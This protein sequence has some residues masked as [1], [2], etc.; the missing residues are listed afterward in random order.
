MEAEKIEAA[1]Q[2]CYL[3]S[4]DDESVAVKCFNAFKKNLKENPSE[5]YFALRDALEPVI[6]LVDWNE[7]DF[8]LNHLDMMARGR[9][10]PVNLKDSG[11]GFDNPGDFF[12]AVNDVLS[13][14]GAN[15]WHWET[16]ESM[17]CSFMSRTE[18]CDKIYRAAEVLGFSEDSGCGMTCCA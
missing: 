9:G 5:L 18:D 6:S 11:I 7:L 16:G 3:L 17:Y 15:L 12:Y 2:L 14:H 10:L 13:K 8:M 4:W 1:K